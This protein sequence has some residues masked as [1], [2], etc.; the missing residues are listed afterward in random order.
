[1]LYL[2]TSPKSNSVT[3]AMHAVKKSLRDEPVQAVPLWLRDAHTKTNKA[4]GHG[5]GYLYSHDYPS[6][7]S[8]Q[9]FMLSPQQFYVPGH[10]G[11]EAA[12]AQRLEQLKKLKAGMQQRDASA[13]D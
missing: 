11:A 4:L 3:R 6:G 8:G 7:I 2:A 5:K 1:V 10:C 12:T 9:E 13:Q